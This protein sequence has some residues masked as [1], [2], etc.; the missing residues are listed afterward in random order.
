LIVKLLVFDKMKPLPTLG[1][2]VTVGDLNGNVCGTDR[3]RQTAFRQA[4][5]NITAQSS[6]QSAAVVFAFLSATPGTISDNF[7][8]IK[9]SFHS[10][11]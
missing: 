8:N 6:G 1:T 7:L 3:K 4:V 2:A 11:Y 10:R 9:N 5:W